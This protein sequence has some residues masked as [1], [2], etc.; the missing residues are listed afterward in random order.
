MAS[1]PP[2]LAK[3]T[4]PKI[5]GSRIVIL[6]E[7]KTDPLTAKTANVML[8]C[9]GDDVV[10]VLDSTQAG[11]TAEELLGVGG[12]TPIVASLDDV[13]L[14][15]G[16]GPDTLLIG[17]ATAGGK[18]PPEWRAL[19]LDAV[20]RGMSVVSGMH[21]FLSDD[22]ELVAA[23]AAAGVQLHDVRKNNEK[24]VATRLDLTDDCLRVLT[25]GQDCSVGKM[26]SALEIARGLERS[27]VDAKFVA[28]GQTGIMVEGDGLPIDCVV[29]DFVNGA[30]EK[31]VRQNLSHEVMVV[32]GQA[33]ITHPRFSAVSLGL[34]HGTNPHAMIY[35]YEAGR[36]AMRGME[37]LPLPTH[38]Q[39]IDAYEHM[40]AFGNPAKVI[41][42]AMNSRKLSAEAAEV[43]R[44]RMRAE[45]GLPVAD[46]IRHGPDELV[47]AILAY[48][49]SRN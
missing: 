32:E 12:D 10:A 22:A 43:E 17:V 25:V 16:K 40:A 4:R 42:I 38:R 2:P 39:V 46:P 47:E 49:K 14:I 27:G 7:G 36:D 29:S 31:L 35:V 5:G 19:C 28:T 6:T 18:I 48:K 45:F 11:K 33:T 34:L 26:L 8:R 24:E 21:Q 30:C 23:A 1:S 3:S 37:Y 41:G 20:R 9:R 13:A 44:E 15:D